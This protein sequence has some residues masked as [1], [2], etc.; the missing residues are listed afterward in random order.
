MDRHNYTL[1]QNIQLQ[2]T[3]HGSFFRQEGRVR[4]KGANSSAVVRQ[5]LNL[6]A[7]QHTHHG[8]FFKRHIRHARPSALRVIFFTV[9]AAENLLQHK[10]GRSVCNEA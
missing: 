6:T 10:G 8:F 5:N 3:R 7:P 1:A 9:P 4:S 2:I